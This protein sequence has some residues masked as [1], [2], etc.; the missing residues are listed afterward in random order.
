MTGEKSSKESAT[1]V[2]TPEESA[3]PESVEEDSSTEVKERAT[4]SVGEVVYQSDGEGTPEEKVDANEVPRKQS[5]E[6][7]LMRLSLTRNKLRMNPVQR[8]LLRLWPRNQR[9]K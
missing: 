1:E 5:L 7:Q 6:R 9:R 8:N 3:S 2:S 4:E